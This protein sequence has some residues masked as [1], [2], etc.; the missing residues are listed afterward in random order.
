MYIYI[1]YFVN[2]FNFFLHTFLGRTDD[3]LIEKIKHMGHPQSGTNLR[4]MYIYCGIAIL[5]HAGYHHSR[6]NVRQIYIYIMLDDFNPSSNVYYVG[7]FYSVLKCI[8]CWVIVFHPQIILCWVIVSCL[9]A[10][11]MLN[12]FNPSSNVYY[13]GWT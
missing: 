12:N 13:V 4:R 11:I 8:L 9:Q 5:K 3:N 2:I 1:F 10:Y 7:W 6:T